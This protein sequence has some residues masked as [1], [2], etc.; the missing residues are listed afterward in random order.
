MTDPQLWT[1]DDDARLFE[2]VEEGLPWHVVAQWMGR[3]VQSCR[4]R[5]YRGGRATRTRRDWS[6]LEDERLLTLHEADL[7]WAT[8]ARLMG[9]S[10][11]SCEK[12]YRRLTIA[13]PP[14]SPAERVW[15]LIIE[16]DGWETAIARRS[17]VEV[18]GIYERMRHTIDGLRVET[19]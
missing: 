5:H 4:M 8:I 12:R 17:E 13:Q 14:A 10:M 6:T 15:L 2:L 1:P 11:E 19:G 18:R 9:R 7:P 16:A 3:T